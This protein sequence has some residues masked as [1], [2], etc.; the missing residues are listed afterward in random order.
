MFSFIAAFAQTAPSPAVLEQVLTKRLVALRPGGMTERN[1]LFQDV[2][3]GAPAG[4]S[5]PFQVTLAIR[6]YGPGY[7]ANRYYGETCVSRIERTQYTLMRDINGMW[8][9]DG[10]MTPP[11]ANKQCKPNPA[12]GTSSIPLTSV[13]G[14]PAPAGQPAATPPAG[15]NGGAGTIARGTYECWANGQARMLMNFSIRTESQYV[16]SDGRPGS[17]A[18][19]PGGR[20]TF[21]GGALDGVLPAGFYAVYYGPGGRPTVSFRNSGGSEVTFC[22]KVR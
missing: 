13:P 6:D 4:D 19:G 15:G 1:V 9:V 20:V 22:Q 17:Y 5:Y 8:Q 18:L 10:A 3:A 14:S 21:R 12:P 2:R 11:L 7:P 16:G